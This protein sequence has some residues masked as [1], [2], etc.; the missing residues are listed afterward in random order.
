G[1]DDTASDNA[2]EDH[3]HNLRKKLG[4]T[5]IKNIRGVGYIIENR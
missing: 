1:W 3:I 4:S 5:L 2:I